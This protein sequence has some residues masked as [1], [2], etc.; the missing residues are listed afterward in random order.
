MHPLFHHF[1]A[2]ANG[3]D[4]LL[5]LQ[6][7]RIFDGDLRV[8][9]VKSSVSQPT[10]CPFLEAFHGDAL[11]EGTR[12]C[13]RT[14]N[15][16]HLIHP[17]IDLLIFTWTSRSHGSTYGWMKLQRSIEGFQQGVGTKGSREEE[18]LCTFVGGHHQVLQ[19]IT[20]IEQNGIA[21]V[22]SIPYIDWIKNHCRRDIVAAQFFPQALQTALTEP[23]HEVDVITKSISFFDQFTVAV[24]LWHVHHSGTGC[25]SKP[26]P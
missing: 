17:V 16:I 26:C 7:S 22:Y 10:G 19:G 23:S 15:L 4:L 25:I 12:L 9:E 1:D 18:T 14:K 20:H 3:H 24:A 8:N 5:R 13:Q 21:K 6:T 11:A 2:V